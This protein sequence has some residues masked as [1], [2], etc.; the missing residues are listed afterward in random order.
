[1]YLVVWLV[2]RGAVKIMKKCSLFDKI[3]GGVSVSGVAGAA[4]DDK[5]LELETR[6]DKILELETRLARNTLSAKRVSSSKIL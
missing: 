5:I 4:Q 2:T 3:A 1:M 6:L